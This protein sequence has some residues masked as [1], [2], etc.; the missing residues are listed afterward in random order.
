QV[1]EVSKST[2]RRSESR[3]S[4]QVGFMA[5]DY[6]KRVK[7]SCHTDVNG[8]RMWPVR[9]TCARATGGKTFGA[10]SFNSSWVPTWW[11]TRAG[12]ACAHA[13]SRHR[14]RKDRL[15]V[16]RRRGCGRRSVQCTGTP[17]N[18]D[19]RTRLSLGVGQ[20]YPRVRD[21]NKNSAYLIGQTTAISFD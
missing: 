21:V 15:R 4:K 14:K 18:I 10:A 5:G 20:L 8:V 12:C 13:T 2:I 7:V 9:T 1:C 6:N 16:Q 17:P 19:M 11:G 3:R